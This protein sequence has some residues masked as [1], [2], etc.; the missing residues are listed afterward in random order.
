MLMA[1]DGELFV[2]TSG[3]LCTLKCCVAVSGLNQM[4]KLLLYGVVHLPYTQ[5]FYMLNTP[6]EQNWTSHV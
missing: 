1:A 3:H 6:F 4:V 2:T 5:P